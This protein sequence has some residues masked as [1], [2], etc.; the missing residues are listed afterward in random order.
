MRKI[1]S[2]SNSPSAIT[3]GLGW[4][5]RSSVLESVFVGGDSIALKPSPVARERGVVTP[6]LP[7]GPLICWTRLV[8]SLT[9]LGVSPRARVSGISFSWHLVSVHR[10]FA[11]G[12]KGGWFCKPPWEVQS[13]GLS[14]SIPSRS[15]A[16]QVPLLCSFCNLQGIFW[17]ELAGSIHAWFERPRAISRSA[18][19]TSIWPSLSYSGPDIE[20][21]VRRKKKVLT[22]RKR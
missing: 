16:I 12:E 14:T 13:G 22:I 6:K 8:I 18:L 7:D 17:T 4:L 19:W 11:T 9:G 3:W 15:G 10:R 5:T 2:N 21:S 20:S 1:W